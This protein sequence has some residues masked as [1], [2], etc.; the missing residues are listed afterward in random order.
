MLTGANFVKLYFISGMVDF[1]F[2]ICEKLLVSEIGFCLIPYWL[3]G[4]ASGVWNIF[5]N[6]NGIRWGGSFRVLVGSALIDVV[7]SIM[8]AIF[9]IGNKCG[10]KYG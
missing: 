9:P 10:D 1:V 4:M 7:V 5:V 2:L 6:G 3:N 8:L